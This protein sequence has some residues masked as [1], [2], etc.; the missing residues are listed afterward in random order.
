MAKDRKFHYEFIHKPL[1][2]F[3]DKYKI[4]Y[5]SNESFNM[6]LESLSYLRNSKDISGETYHFCRLMFTQYNNN[7]K[8]IKHLQSIE[9]RKQAQSFISRKKIRNFIF[10]RDGYKCLKCSSRNNLSIDHILSINKGGLN[11][12]SNLQTLC[13]SCNSVKKDNFKDF[14]NGRK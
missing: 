4:I 7:L 8:K 12:L 6:L 3:N 13:V 1:Y 14:R 10:K 2:K 9:P 11:K 5:L